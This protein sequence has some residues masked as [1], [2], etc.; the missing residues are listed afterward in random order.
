VPI[1]GLF[2]PQKPGQEGYREAA[3]ESTKGD[4]IPE[5]LA[6]TG[7]SILAESGPAPK[8]FPYCRHSSPWIRVDLFLATVLLGVMRSQHELSPATQYSISSCRPGAAVR[9]RVSL[10]VAYFHVRMA[11]AG[12]PLV[13][14]APAL[15]PRGSLPPVS[16][17]TGTSS[18]PVAG[19]VLFCN[20]RRFSTSGLKRQ[21]RGKLPLQPAFM[22]V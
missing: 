7:E 6:D 15:T 4:E 14:P 16:L 8:G 11:A 21:F 18:P 17:P 9:G 10:R 12:H 19:R 22:R 5:N 2:G 13:A 20:S 1:P 3:V